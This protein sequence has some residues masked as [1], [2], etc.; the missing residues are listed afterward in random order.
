MPAQQRLRA[1]DERRPAWAREHLAERRH[2]QP[3]TTAKTRPADLALEHRELMAKD[4]DLDVV[5]QLAGR[6]G[7]Q[8]DCPTQQQIGEGEKHGADLLPR[9]R[10]D[11]TKHAGHADDRGFLC[12]SGLMHEYAQVA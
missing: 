11:P 7:R 8:P 1:H 6:A 12:P 9:K 3:L 5:V 4:H 2:D 10:A